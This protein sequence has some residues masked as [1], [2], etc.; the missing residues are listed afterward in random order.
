MLSLLIII[1]MYT[2]H[3]IIVYMPNVLL[4]FVHSGGRGGIQLRR[5]VITI[6]L[7]IIILIILFIAV[8]TTIV[9]PTRSPS[10]AADRRSYRCVAYRPGWTF[11]PVCNCRSLFAVEDF[12]LLAK[13][14]STRMVDGVRSKCCWPP[15]RPPVTQ[16]WCRRTWNTKR[17]SSD[18]S[19]VDSYQFYYYCHL[20]R[21]YYYILYKIL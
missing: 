1:L 2:V 4:L 3:T 7:L 8:M 19:T 11:R 12:Y 9:R 18:I 5:S 10:Q 20:R 6:I 15:S 21:S 16:P 13:S 17:K 14:A